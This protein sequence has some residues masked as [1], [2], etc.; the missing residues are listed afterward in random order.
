VSISGCR[1]RVRG[2][3]LAP[4]LASDGWNLAGQ[5]V[6]FVRSRAVLPRARAAAERA[7]L[8]V[9]EVGAPPF[10]TEARVSVWINSFRQKGTGECSKCS[11]HWGSLRQTG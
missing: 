1:C 10:G 4:D 3:R 8:D 11:R 5:I 9:I 2:L 7:G 6:V